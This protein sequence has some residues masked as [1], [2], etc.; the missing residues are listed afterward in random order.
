MKKALPYLITALVG[1]LIVVTVIC[2]NSVWN[3]KDTVGLMQLLSDAFFVA[4]VSIGGIGLLVFVSNNGVFDMLGYAIGM[5]LTVLSKHRK[6][7][8]FKEYRDAKEAKGKRSSAFMLI[9]GLAYTA[10]AVAFLIAFL[11]LDK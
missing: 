5:L 2:A 4:G 1:A 6:Y 10:V 7:R 3:I 8:D 9:V 11:Q